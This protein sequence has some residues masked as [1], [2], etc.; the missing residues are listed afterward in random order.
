MI[1]AEKQLI[2]E[3]KQLKELYGFRSIEQVIKTLVTNAKLLLLEKTEGKK[4]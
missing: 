4:Q 3:L 1:K 2:S